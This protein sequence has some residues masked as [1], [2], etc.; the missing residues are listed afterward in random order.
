MRIYDEVQ[1]DK[2]SLFFS[3]D[4]FSREEGGQREG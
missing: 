2:M 3:N 1:G 4:Y